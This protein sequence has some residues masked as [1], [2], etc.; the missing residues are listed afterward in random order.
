M[1]VIN[2]PMPIPTTSD[3]D[4]S[5]SSS[6]N[7]PAKKRTGSAKR[8][9]AIPKRRVP[10]KVEP[11]E[12]TPAVMWTQRSQQALGAIVEALFNNPMQKT[13][14]TNLLN[15]PAIV[16][17]SPQEWS[18]DLENHQKKDRKVINPSNVMNHQQLAPKKKAARTAVK[19]APH[20]HPTKRSPSTKKPTCHDSIQ[21]PSPEPAT[22]PSTS[23]SD[24][25]L[26]TLDLPTHSVW[27]SP[28]Q[29]QE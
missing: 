1:T 9:P 12:H 26:F 23:S 8:K 5:V 27:D 25:D 16:N 14:V 10:L 24:E 22:L 11:I 28:P 13:F 4:H 3:S 18:S 2:P 15:L 6:T 7:S 19:D 17:G 20:K 29:R 21:K